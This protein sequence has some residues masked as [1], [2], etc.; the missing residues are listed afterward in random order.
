MK[1]L[2]VVLNVALLVAVGFLF[3]KIYGAP[4][5]GKPDSENQVA[6]NLDHQ[7][8]NGVKIAYINTDSLVEKYAYHKELKVKL[9]EKAKVLEA[10]LAQKSKVFEENLVLLRERADKMNQQQLQAAEAELQ[11]KQQLLYQYRDERAAELAK[12]EQ[13]LSVLIKDDMDEVMES[14][15]NEFGLDYILSFDPNSILLSANEQYDITDIVVKRLNE[16]H[17]KKDKE[18]EKTE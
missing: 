15:K 3:F 6:S 17:G 5:S 4:S 8:F 18:T 2:S 7:E 1:S 13:D 16:S 9:E 14:I 10:D 12:E 11:Q